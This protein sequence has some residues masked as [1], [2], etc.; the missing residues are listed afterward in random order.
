M[1]CGKNG[2]LLVGKY[3]A[4]SHQETFFTEGYHDY[5]NVSSFGAWAALQLPPELKN[6]KNPT[7]KKN[8][9]L[10][11][12]QIIIGND[13]WIGRGCT[14][15]AGSIIGNGAVIGTNSVVKKKIP[16]YSIAVGNPA[17]V[18]KYRFEPEIIRKL[19]AIKWWNWNIKKIL[20]N[21][22]LMNEPKK[23]VDTH[24]SK[25][26]EQYP[27]DSLTNALR[28]FKYKGFKIFSTIADFDSQ[29]PIYGK[30]IEDFAES[31]LHNAILVFH[32]PKKF[33]YDDLQKRL[34]AVW[35]PCEDKFIFAIR[36]ED[37]FAFSIESL[38]E[39]DVFITTREFDSLLALDFLTNRIDVRYALDDLVFF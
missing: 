29:R 36:S 1:Q 7:H 16:P 2:H 25:D 19:L 21:L 28:D 8:Y 5:K 3:C 30:I 12:A 22:E 11:R 15:L 31:E 14:I 24:Y 18:V 13:V 6:F 26:L 38:R 23:F 9:R 20:N 10:T 32:V 34:S 33:S 27:H 35:K 39:S 17:R 4:I 37:D